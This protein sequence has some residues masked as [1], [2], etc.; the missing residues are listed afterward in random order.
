MGTGVPSLRQRSWS[1]KLPT[2]LH[3]APRLWMSGE[4]LLL[5]LYIYAFMAWTGE[6]YLHSE[7]ILK[8][9]TVS[10]HIFCRIINNTLLQCYKVKQSHYRPGQALRVP[11]GWGSKISRQFAHEGG[12]LVIPTHRPPLPPGNIPGTHFC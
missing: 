3:L 6:V 4:I 12:K 7:A 8:I 2:Y 11:G 5:S 9:S 10:F 1:M